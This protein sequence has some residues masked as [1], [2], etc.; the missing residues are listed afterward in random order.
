VTAAVVISPDHR[1]GW[2][3]EVRDRDGDRAGFPDL[4]AAERFA[5]RY[6]VEHWDGSGDVLVLD[7]DGRLLGSA[8]LREARR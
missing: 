7:R 2:C 1:T 8:C 3:A 6:I 5:R 4:W